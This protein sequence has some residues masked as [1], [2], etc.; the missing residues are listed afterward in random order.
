MLLSIG[1]MVKNEEKYLEQCLQGLT[2]ILSY[3]EAELIVVDTGST[4]RTVEIARK[5]TDRVYE[6]SWTNDF[7]E[8][9]NIVLGYTSGEWFFFV[10][11]DEVLTDASGIIDFFRSGKYK[12][13][14]SGFIQLKN[15]TRSDETQSSL[16]HAARLFRNDKDFHF[17]GAIH[18]Q[19]HFKGPMAHIPGE[20]VHYGYI[21]DDPALME[22]KFERNV[23]LLKAALRDDPENLYY[24]FQLS[25]SYAMHNMHKEAL[26]PALK[27]YNLAKKQ[28]FSHYQYTGERLISAYLQNDMPADA[29]RLC[30]EML[31]VPQNN[32]IDIHFSLAIALVELG[33]IT[34][35]IEVYEKYLLVLRDFREGRFQLGP[36]RAI[37]SINKDQEVYN[38]LCSL[39]RKVGDHK[40]ALENARKI[41]KPEVAELAMSTVVDIFIKQQQYGEIADLRNEWRDEPDVLKAIEVAIESRWLSL[42]DEARRELVLTSMNED[43]DYGRLNLVRADFYGFGRISDAVWS[44]IEAF[45]FIDHSDYYAEYLFALIRHDKSIMEHLAS[46]RESM[47]S[48]YSYYLVQL[49]SDCIDLLNQ[50]VCSDTH[51]QDPSDP[52]VQR[53]RAAFA[54]GIL[55]ESKLPED[56][57]TRLFDNYLAWGIAFLEHNYREEVLNE[58]RMSW[59][60]NGADGF[61]VYMRLAKRT[62][63]TSADYVRYLRLALAQDSSMKRGIELLLSDVQERL[64]N[65]E[66][67]ELN[68]L[69]KSIQGSIKEALNAGELETA[70]MLVNE[71]EDA[72]GIDAPLC[73]AKGIILMTD[74]KLDEAEKFFLHGLMLEPQNVDLLFNLGYLHE[75]L[76]N[77]RVAFDYYSRAFSKADDEMITD[78]ISHALVGLRSGQKDASSDEFVTGEVAS[79]VDAH[80][81]VLRKALQEGR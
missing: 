62:E 55:L 36:S 66:Q 28:K 10:D 25:Q 59:I 58:G 3:I 43:S 22:Y 4:D 15:I 34:E 47:I 67:D 2:P 40:R 79:V 78:E 71:Y 51:W 80:I 52:E 70:V 68:T 29:E 56:D 73:S 35:A 75:Y 46:L 23:E 53:V 8:M 12:K 17:S 50:Y 11:G 21:S 16:F 19:P 57:F 13:Y 9:R 27:A 54:Y 64:A 37:L 60:R 81:S 76:G 74:G 30:R 26:E 33:R 31:K 49:Y 7:S 77:K 48:G 32:S 63:R 45:S 18:E 24:L 5:F 14:N 61:L 72:V 69:K 6:H 20:I 65:P 44:H 1:L 38:A 39:Y 42:S 41:E